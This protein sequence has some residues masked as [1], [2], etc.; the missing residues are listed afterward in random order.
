[1]I[2]G[3][4]RATTIWQPAISPVL[5]SNAMSPPITPNTDL[6]DLARTHEPER[7]LAATLAPEPQRA[8]LIALSA[9]AADLQ[10][11]PATATDP[12]LGEI[13]LQWWRDNL[14]ATAAG[15]IS[16][17]PVA[18]AL[19]AA[20]QAYHL[21]VPLLV[22]ITEARAWDLYDDPMSDAAAL[23]GYLSKTE[24]ILFEL[25]LRILGVPAGDAGALA[26]P[27]GRAFGLTRLLARLPEHLARGRMPLPLTLLAQ[28]GLTPEV[29]FAGTGT[30]ALRGLIATMTKDISGTLATLR[31]QINALS[32]PLRVA[33]L[34]LATIPPYLH[35]IGQQRRN[36]LRDIADLA[37]LARVCRIALAHTLGRI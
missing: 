1:M 12:L 33:L 15:G 22:A 25:A 21:P 32:K 29:I 9:F 6:H 37:P 19:G 8:A 23:D 11:I 35:R 17:A 20:I 30:V 31:P 3:E 2:A 13:R 24:A 28:H 4:V 7:Y 16:G 36:P 18:D 5:P 14:E 10:R 34:P 27:A 26:A